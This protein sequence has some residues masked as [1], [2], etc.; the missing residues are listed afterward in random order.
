ME[1]KSRQLDSTSSQL[2]KAE[3]TVE[4]F[5]SMDIGLQ[6]SQ[7]PSRQSFSVTPHKNRDRSSLAS[8][9]SEISVD[10]DLQVLNTPPPF[11]QFT[12]H[13]KILTETRY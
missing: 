11:G 10:D 1:V 6:G 5:E 12:A 2:K 4:D 13:G 7:H 3:K 9:K 8:T